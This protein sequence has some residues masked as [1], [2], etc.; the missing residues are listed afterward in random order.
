[1]Q[2]F[3]HTC[4]VRQSYF[5]VCWRSLDF[6]LRQP[7]RFW[8]YETKFLFQSFAWENA[9]TCVVL[10]NRTGISAKAIVWLLGGKRNENFWIINFARFC[11]L[12]VNFLIVIKLIEMLEKFPKAFAC[13]TIKPQS[14]GHFFCKPVTPFWW[15]YLRFY[16]GY[17][18]RFDQHDHSTQNLC[19]ENARAPQ[20]DIV[21]FSGSTLQLISCS[22]VVTPSW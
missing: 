2:T 4:C 7:L 6:K 21:I 9:R 15:H 22:L 14:F 13:E 18:A 1:M 5:Y 19:I 11:G 17:N 20:E 12:V 16:P 10:A 8:F 3:A